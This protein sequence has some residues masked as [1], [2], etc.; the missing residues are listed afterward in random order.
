MLSW[1]VLHNYGFDSSKVLPKEQLQDKKLVN[2]LQTAVQF[3]QQRHIQ[4]INNASVRT[5]SKD[6]IR[7]RNLMH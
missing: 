3:L 7:S 2:E 4:E 1:D 6:V 5:K